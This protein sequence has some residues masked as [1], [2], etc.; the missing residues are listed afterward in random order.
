MF[1]LEYLQ[2]FS[3]TYLPD[4]KSLTNTASSTTA[5]ETLPKFNILENQS[6]LNLLAIGTANSSVH[7]YVFGT[8][9]LAS[10]QLDGYLQEPCSIHQMY[11]SQNLDTMYVTAHTNSNL[12]RIVLIDS[13]L[14]KTH[15]K[16]LYSIASKHEHLKALLDYLFSTITTIKENWENI[17]LEMDTKLSKYAARVPKGGITAD[18]LDLLMFGTYTNEI[19]EFLVHDLTKKG[20]EKFG[21]IIEMSYGSIQKL[22]L[23]YV[24]KMG[25]NI[26]YHLAELR[27]LARLKS[28]FFVMGLYEKNVT[29]AIHSNG[30]FLIK[31]G[32]MQQIINQSI[33]SYKAFFRWLYTSVMHLIDEPVPPEIP[34]M[35]QQDQT[36]IAEFLMNF[37]RIGGEN[38]E[39]IMER[40]GQYLANAPL[41]IER[42]MNNNEWD[43]FLKENSCFAD[44]PLILKHYKEMSL[45][46]QLNHL[47]QSIDAIFAK[48]K[49]AVMGRFKTIAALT[50]FRLLGKICSSRIN[51]ENNTTYMAFLCSEAPCELMCFLEVAKNKTRCVYVSFFHNKKY[52]VMDL[53]FYSAKFLTV[54]LQHSNTTVLCQL[55]L[56]AIT[57][58]L[59]DI[60]PKAAVYEQNI[61]KVNACELAAPYK[62]I[63]SMLAKQIAV[64]GSRS[65]CIVLA[66]NKRQ[67]RIYEM[68]AE[69]EEEEDVDMSTN[70]VRDSDMSVL[71][72][73]ISD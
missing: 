5:N 42:N 72:S 20:L 63:D 57:D 41:T 14:L 19:E 35:T 73:F 56:A 54:L 15:G 45:V 40:L 30:A 68:E 55:Q 8:L 59:V 10:I 67:V 7:L 44:H 52:D 17:L 39:L 4:I 32:E 21:Q 70:T 58:K 53:S 51:S 46:Q 66:D 11:F 18:F 23:K 71:D 37:D 28:R 69:E 22:L 49:K 65:V 48:P 61:P 16:E 33:V 62:H 1:K 50:C 12:V 34:K 29:E 43:L 2:D 9:P 47:K 26:S 25:Q 27:G 60:N 13:C 64:S 31:T 24:A 6:E 36:S 38:S 3:S